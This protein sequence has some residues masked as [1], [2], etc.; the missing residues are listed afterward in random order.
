VVEEQPEEV[1]RLCRRLDMSL[2]GFEVLSGVDRKRRAM[3]EMSVVVD[4]GWGRSSYPAITGAWVV[5]DLGGLCRVQ[6]L[7]LADDGKWRLAPDADAEWW[8][9]VEL[10]PMAPPSEPKRVTPK[11]REQKRMV[12]GDEMLP[13][14]ALIFRRPA[15]DTPRGG[16]VPGRPRPAR[17]AVEPRAHGGGGQGGRS[18]SGR[19]HVRR[20]SASGRHELGGRRASDGCARARSTSR[21]A[22]GASPQAV[23]VS[24]SDAVSA[25][26]RRA[27][28]HPRPAG[29][30]VCRKGS[31]VRHGRSWVPARLRRIPL[32]RFDQRQAKL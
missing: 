11:T 26:A 18:S 10:D 23:G 30:A 14:F 13:R 16:R 21:T 5:A 24:A 27:P 29:V 28:E 1:R 12:R 6:E 2:S 20:R 17:S 3:W 25:R 22:G 32:C 8:R 19:A 15:S 9:D 4:V 7:R 31:E